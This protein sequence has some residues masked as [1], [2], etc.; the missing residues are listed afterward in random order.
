[1]PVGVAVTAVE[2]LNILFA[3]LLTG[4]TL[5]RQPLFGNAFTLFAYR[6]TFAADKMLQVVIEAGVVAVKPMKLAACAFNQIG[7]SGKF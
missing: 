3:D 4:F 5:Q 6:F 7:L 1:M 2:E